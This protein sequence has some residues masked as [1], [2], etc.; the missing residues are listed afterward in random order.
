MIEVT[1]TIRSI[2]EQYPETRAVFIAN[3]LDDLVDKRNLE[4]VGAFLTI[5]SALKM[6][7]KDLV[8]F[9][10]MLSEQI[11]SNHDRIDITL[12][13]EKNEQLDVIGLLPVSV[14]LQVLETFEA[15]RVRLQKEEGLSLAGRFAAA[16][17]GTDWV[18][19]AYG[20]VEEPRMLPDICF[21][22][23]FDFFFAKPFTDRFIKSGVFRKL[24]PW[25]ENE[26]FQGL[27][28]Q[29]PKSR[30]CII[31]VVPAVFVVDEPALEG[32]SVPRTWEDL[33]GSSYER[34]IAMPERS[35]DIPRSIL[36]T[37]Y[38]RFGEEGVR[39]LGRNT[40]SQLHPAQMVKQIKS[41]VKGRPAVSVMPY[42]F[43][44]TVNE[45]E[46]ITVI[47]PEDGAIVSPIYM[48]AKSD[49]GFCR[50]DPRVV[51]RAAELFSSQQMGT[52]F[53]KG[54]FPSLHPKVNN[55]LPDEASFQWIG[56]EFLEGMDSGIILPQV[57]NLFD[58]EIARTE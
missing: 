29:D 51:E 56:W 35:L 53:T 10:N 14:R 1:M 13:E 2:I 37:L 9:M 34:S 49:P 17:E 20:Q 15:L 26:D 57:Y 27:G 47:W 48:L 22:A 25:T 32:R 7:E 36:L 3:G 31:S 6:K 18:A 55:A 39:S 8:A 43:S 21:S 11:S 33:L 45:A 19:E 23:G 44:R 5:E 50:A 42:F 16:Q 24:M 41:A 28:L 4:K 52:I 40:A 38:A 12:A 54:Y 58:E 46:G 30:Y